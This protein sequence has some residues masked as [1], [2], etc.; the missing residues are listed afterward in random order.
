MPGISFAR[1]HM[2][3]LLG[4]GLLAVPSLPATAAEIMRKPVPGFPISAAIEVPPGYDTVYLSGVGPDPAE[5]A[6]D[7]ES[8]TR[9]ELKRIAAELKAMHLGLGDVVQM[10]VFM[11]PDPKLGKM[12][13]AGMMKAYKERFGTGEQP[14]MPTRSAFQVAALAGPGMLIEIEVVAVRKLGS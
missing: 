7:T 4:M 2:A 6:M 9:S 8:Q 3:C 1:I 12:D 14:N 10:H 11:A 13:F 5:K